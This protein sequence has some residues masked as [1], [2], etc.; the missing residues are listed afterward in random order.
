MA[1][2][3]IYL[4]V[5]NDCPYQA[6]NN[7]WSSINDI[8][9]IDINQFYLYR[10]NNILTKYN[11]IFE[12]LF[13]DKKW[14]H[15]EIYFTLST[16]LLLRNSIAVLQLLRKCGL[17]C[18]LPLSTG[19]VSPDKT[20]NRWTNLEPSFRSSNR[21]STFKGGVRCHGKNKHY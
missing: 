7:W 2:L 21:L 4:E 12:W 5:Q 1:Q 17:L 3:I 15:C 9:C 19:R 14:H 8:T 18:I 16:F 11:C 10:P 6:E 13:E 20:S